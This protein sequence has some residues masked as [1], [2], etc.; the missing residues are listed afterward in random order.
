MGRRNKPLGIRA[1]AALSLLGALLF[2]TK[3]AMAYLPNIEPVSLLVM[4]YAVVLGRKALFPIYI[5]VVM[6]MLIWGVSIWTIAYCYVWTILAL[7]ARALRRM[8]SPLGWA[9]LSGAF[10][11]CFGLLCTIINLFIGGWELA[12]TWWLA[13]V[14]FDVLH[15][16]G[17]FAMA[18]VLFT[19]CKRVLSALW[20]NIE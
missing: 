11:L 5:F 14:P 16:A 13:G 2:V 18:L 19:P 12:V 8:E 9:V 7:L 10:G 1:L 6:D 17:N 4:V 15:C 3:T 20:A